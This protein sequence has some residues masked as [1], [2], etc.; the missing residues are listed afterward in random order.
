MP[1][2]PLD[3]SAATA[4]GST[5]LDAGSGRSADRSVGDLVSAVS[6]DLTR[7]VRDEL[8]LAQAEVTDKAKQAGVGVGAFGAAG[9]LAL[10]ALGVLLAAAVL[11][12][13]TVLPAWLAALLVAVV[14]LVVAGI[15]ALV[16]RKKVQEAAPP[17]P[18]RAVESVRTDVQEIKETI[19]R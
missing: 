7:L 8:R 12:L 6:A 4:T 9:V 3:P 14:V 10:Y 1:A 5:A 18:T 15:A 17:V 2:D 13:A 19:K 11:G 16:G